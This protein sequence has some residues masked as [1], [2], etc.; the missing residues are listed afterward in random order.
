MTDDDPPP[1]ALPLGRRNYAQFAERYAAM[2][3][4]K[5][6]NAFYDRPAMQS[7]LPDVA[8]R[9]VLDAGCGPGHYAAGSRGAGRA[10]S[11]ST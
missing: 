6:H 3:P 5:P 10:W 8:G 2:T 9:D 11:A 7:L 4:S 1:E